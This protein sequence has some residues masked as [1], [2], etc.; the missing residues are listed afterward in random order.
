MRLRPHG[1]P[2]RLVIIDGNDGTGKSTLLGGIEQRLRERGYDVLRTSQPTTEAREL[3]AFKVYL[4][5][6]ERRD[7]IDYRALLCMMIGDRLQHAHQI[8]KPALAAGQIVLCDRYIF[9]QMVTTRTRGYQDEPWT[10]E[11]YQ[12]VIA[13]D[14][15]I[16][17]DA[18]P[19]LVCARITAR[20][21]AR[22]AF[23]ELD[24]VRKNLVEFRRLA[25]VFGLD[26]IDTAELGIPEAL[27][28]AIELVDK[29]L[30][31]ASDDE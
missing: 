26:T 31:T 29:I 20:S 11:L 21:E 13:P 6:P 17:T 24:H 14:V 23:H 2:G 3:D 10:Y 19:A 8:I 9:T 5:E 7:E 25:G 1:L 4:F 16:I 15:G 30:P 22:E 28:Q 12:H 18:D 27:H